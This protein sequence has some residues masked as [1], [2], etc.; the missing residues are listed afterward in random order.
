MTGLQLTD[1]MRILFQGDSITDCSRSWFANDSL[2]N[3]YVSLVA[4]HLQTHYPGKNITCI[5]RGVSG[6]CIDD[7]RRRW[8]KDCLKLKPDVLS[9]LIGVNDAW[10][11]FG[12]LSTRD[13]EAFYNDYYEILKQTKEQLNPRF[14]LCEPFLLPVSDDIVT[15]RQTLDAKIVLIKQLA[16]EFNAIY[17]PFDT[18]FSEALKNT[19]P[20]YWAGDGVHPTSAGH[21]L[22]AKEWILR[23]LGNK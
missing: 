23:V 19:R 21:A 16:A 7:L 11:S 18:M 4:S 1:N 12:A 5:N 14:V 2:G 3:G 17:V 6:D 10:Q 8:N 20:S 9:I 22:M 13:D 15:V